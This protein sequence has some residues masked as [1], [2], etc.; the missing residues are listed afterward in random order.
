ML[1][2]FAMV[3]LCTVVVLSELPAQDDP[4]PPGAVRRYG[5][6]RWRHGDS[7]AVAVSPGGKLLATTTQSSFEMRIWNVAT[8]KVVRKV[9]LPEFNALPVFLADG[10]LIVGRLNRPLGLIVDLET[11]KTRELRATPEPDAVAV[12]FALG[13]NN[14]LLAAGLNTGTALLLDPETGDVVRRFTVP[15]ETNSVDAIHLSKDGRILIT[16]S[17]G[18]IRVWD[19]VTTKRIRTYTAKEG[20]FTTF[21]ISPDDKWIATSSKGVFQV[22]EVDSEEEVA[23]VEAGD[24]FASDMTFVPAGDRIVIV[25]TNGGLI[26]WQPKQG[27]PFETLLPPDTDNRFRC[28]FVDRKAEIAAMTDGS[29]ITVIQAGTGKH[30]TDHKDASREI[31][32]IHPSVTGDGSLL[33]EEGGGILSRW[34]SKTGKPGPR[35]AL[36]EKDKAI[37]AISHNRKLIAV[38]HND[39]RQIRLT[40]LGK[41]RNLWLV[42]GHTK[43]S[44]HFC[45]SPDDRFLSTIGDDDT[46]QIREVATGKKVA[47]IATG[48]DGVNYS[49]WTR[50]SRLL[51]AFVPK[52]KQLHVWELATMTLRCR[53]PAVNLTNY[54]LSPDSKKVAF[55]APEGGCVHDLL[56]GNLL[57]RDTAS[58]TPE[59][60]VWSPDGETVVM[61]TRQGQ[62]TAYAAAD[63]KRRNSF[64][65]HES[66]IADLAFESGSSR[67]LY[68]AGGDGTVVQWDLTAI[69]PE[70]VA[71]AKSA[72]PAEQSWNDLAS[73]DSKLAARG[74]AQ[75]RDRPAET[76]A[77]LAAHLKPAP[78]MDLSGM[79][80]WIDDLD[81]PKYD[82]R[83]KASRELRQLG[84][85][86]ATALR[87]RLKAGPSA[88]LEQ[89]LTELLAAIEGPVSDPDVLRRLRGVELLERIATPEAVALLERLAGGAAEDRITREAATAVKRLRKGE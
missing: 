71:V 47:S 37:V 19:A 46:I 42:E 62:V 77:L 55:V 4:L 43:N 57:W 74:M 54:V 24:E 2:L 1:R 85:L 16:L 88:E 6:S 73:K 86:T 13:A 27:K 87:D 69:K 52:E 45:F 48:D 14:R 8:G 59:R 50:D 18:R 53:I 60:V 39:N 17:G 3:G 21:A 9:E 79:K 83:A 31:T 30:L 84:G 29:R 26:H 12:C 28:S 51:L 34:D 64:K 75:L 58:G 56:D 63:G 82:V 36:P 61:G 78:A 72:L 23:T 40:E 41:D 7:G 5:S 38:G 89:R 10:R 25:T 70:T 33:F 65:A 80:K 68:S 44:A 49:G 22:F 35:I 11:G 81:S 15:R 66:S 76:V 20:A 67:I 32:R